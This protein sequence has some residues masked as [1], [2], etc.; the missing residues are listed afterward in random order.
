MGVKIT[1]LDEI[2]KQFEKMSTIDGL[3][4]FYGDDLVETYMESI[5]EE[6]P[7][8]NEEQYRNAEKQV[9]DNL[10]KGNEE[11]SIEL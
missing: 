10:S 9:R 8:L 2:Q 3:Y 6:Y 11:F 7:D 1:G 5:K 4:D